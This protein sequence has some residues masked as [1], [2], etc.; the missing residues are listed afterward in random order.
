MLLFTSNYD[1]A[2]VCTRVVE[3]NCLSECN[4]AEC[5]N[6]ECH[7]AECRGAYIL[8]SLRIFVNVHNFLLLGK[9]QLTAE[10]YNFK[11]VSYNCE[12]VHWNGTFVNYNSKF[13]NYNSK[14]V[15]YNGKFVNKSG[16]MVNLYII[17]FSLQKRVCRFTQKSLWDKPR[18]RS[19]KTFSALFTRILAYS[20][21]SYRRI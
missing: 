2:L 10:N 14:F 15:N 16:T 8:P 20:L 1:N 11:F 13:V 12:F 5:R 3:F 17:W 19:Y 21:S 9:L 18:T 4:Y 6:A 7:N